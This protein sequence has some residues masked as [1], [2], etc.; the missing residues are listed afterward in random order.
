[1][2]TAAAGLKPIK[3]LIAASG[4]GGHIFPALF[5]ARALQEQATVIQRTIQIEFVGSGR[6]L[7]ERLIGGAGFARHVVPLGG[8][9]GRGVGGLLQFLVSLPRALLRCQ[10]ILTRFKPDLVIGAGGYA[11]VLPVTLAALRGVPTWV[12]EAEAK[13]GLA[14][15]FLAL[16]VTKLSVVTADLTLWKKR[17]LVV[18]GHPTRPEVRDIPARDPQ[19]GAVRNLLLIGGSQGARA[20]DQVMKELTHF[21]A[22]HT[23]KI[24]HQTR[25]ENEAELRAHYRAAGIDAQVVSFIDNMPEAYAWSDIIISRCGAASIA[26]IAIV[27]RPA[28]LVPLPTSQGGHQTQNAKVLSDAGKALLVIEGAGFCERLQA[29]LQ[30]LLE[31]EAYQ[32]MLNRPK[33]S[34]PQ[35]AATVIAKESLK[36]LEITHS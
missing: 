4:T 20:L 15:A 2:S 10:Q 16:F 6:P 8:L 36:L 14:N 1:M 34:K 3:V 26:E 21:L 9:V 29:A 18:T 19:R 32:A 23:L 33:V 30:T 5:I 13:P 24:F 31:P 28:I 12:H 35:D 22:T 25:P 27:N 11:S 17:D 7:E